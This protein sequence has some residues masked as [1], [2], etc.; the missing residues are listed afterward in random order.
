MPFNMGT[1][2]SCDT[3]SWDGRTFTIGHSTLGVGRNWTSS[4][5]EVGRSKESY[6]GGQGWT[7]SLE[8]QVIQL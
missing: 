4:N 6:D 7:V 8:D 1:A 5:C 2:T 3:E